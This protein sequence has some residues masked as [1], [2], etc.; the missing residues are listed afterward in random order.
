RALQTYLRSIPPHPLSW[1]IASEGGYL[2]LDEELWKQTREDLLGP[3][4]VSRS[5]HLHEQRD[6]TSGYNF[7]Y[8]GRQLDAPVF[9]RDE[10]STCAVLFT[11]PTEYLV[12]R[13]PACVRAL[14]LE[15]AR[16][17]P[18]SFGYASFALLVHPLEWYVARGT[19][20]ELRDRYVGL[21]IYRLEL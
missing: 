19:V 16:E 18:F 1:Y 17:L 14:A 21:D 4:R 10:D 7:E 13:G 11:L 9:A 6:G 20:R 5:V 12:E 2:P 3:C 15:L 8:Y